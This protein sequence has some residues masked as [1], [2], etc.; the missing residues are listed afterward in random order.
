MNRV[1]DDA[2]GLAIS[3]KMRAQ[4]SGLSV[5]GNN[6]ENGIAMLQTAEGALNETHAMLQRMREL[7]VQ[8]ANGKE[9][10]DERKLMDL[11]CQQLKEQINVISHDTEFNTK[12]LLNG[13]YKEA[14]LKIQVGANS[15][16]KI[17]LSIGYIS[18]EGIGLSRISSI[19]TRADAENTLVDL[20]LSINNVSS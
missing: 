15:G 14:T 19:A 4:I 5:A 13:D 2:A 8:A 10:D 20:D 7:A 9:T 11:E 12:K 1:A 6:I 18:A 16:Q 17:E 3:E